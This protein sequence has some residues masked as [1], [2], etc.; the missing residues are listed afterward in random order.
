MAPVSMAAVVS[1]ETEYTP[2]KMKD[3]RQ[4][5]SL[6]SYERKPF[7]DDKLGHPT[8]AATMSAQQNERLRR[9]ILDTDSIYGE[10]D[11]SSMSLNFPDLS[12]N[13][14]SVP[15]TPE[16][17]CTSLSVPS[18]STSVVTGTL[19]SVW[20]MHLNLHVMYMCTTERVGGTKRV[21]WREEGK[22]VSVCICACV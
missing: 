11:N 5:L 21:K 13:L 20:L 22:R 15:E 9:R 10:E 12:E 19:V 14:S 1:M 7:A 6:Y 18:S 4:K 16:L 2:E 17:P 3:N 8:S